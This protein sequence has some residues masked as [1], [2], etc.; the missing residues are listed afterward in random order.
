[1]RDWILTTSTFKGQ[2]LSLSRRSCEILCG[3]TVIQATSARSLELAIGDI[4]AG[5][6]RDETYFIEE[7][8]TRK[9][10]LKRSYREVEKLIACNLDLVVIV[11]A[12][13]PDPQPLFIDRVLTITHEQE[14]PCALV[15]NKEDL[16]LEDIE[17]LL[18]VYRKLEIPLF[19]I[20]TKEKRGLAQLEQYLQEH[21]LEV[22]AFT[23]TSG[24]GKS[25]LINVLIPGT[26]QATGELSLKTNT[27]KQTTSKAQAFRYKTSLVNMEDELLLIDLPGIQSFG[28]GHLT[29]DQVKRAFFDFAPFAKNCAYSN[30]A[31]LYE[32]DCAVKAAIEN[33]EI[34]V[35]R[36]ESY[37]RMIEEI[38]SCQKY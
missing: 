35:S 29:T 38:K 21:K 15:I 12:V 18:E 4:V 9:N 11:A 17:E 27:G 14:I 32:D 3:D 5:S 36:F 8:L 22:V 19:Q 16:G 6:L 34:P 26:T 31:H 1:M 2:I 7:Q 13:E 37:I 33:D 23:G 25:S 28:V 20:S 30:C 10:L 24:V